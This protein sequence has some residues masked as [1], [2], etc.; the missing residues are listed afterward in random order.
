MW[1]KVGFGAVR[2]GNSEFG[3][4]R[5]SNKMIAKGHVATFYLIIKVTSLNYAKVAVFCG[6]FSELDKSDLSKIGPFTASKTTFLNEPI[7]NGPT[8]SDKSNLS[9]NISNKFRMQKRE[10]KR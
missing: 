10:E 4:T 2:L 8:T 1:V 3:P 9:P 5:H 6:L 7:S